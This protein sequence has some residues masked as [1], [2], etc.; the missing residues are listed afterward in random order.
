M[1]ATLIPHA[2]FTEYETVT[3][4]GITYPGHWSWIY[5]ARNDP[6]PAHL[7][8]DGVEEA[9]R[10]EVGSQVHVTEGSSSGGTSVAPRAQVRRRG[11]VGEGV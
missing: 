11:A 7:A 1:A 4:N 9:R 8:V 10:L 5:V 6:E 3:R 2:V